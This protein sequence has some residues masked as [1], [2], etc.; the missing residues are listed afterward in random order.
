MNN[1]QGISDLKGFLDEKVEQYNQPQFIETD[2]IQIPKQ[3]SKKEDVEIAGFLSATIAWGNRVA[4]IKNALRLM[5]M[6]DNQP[7]EFVKDA[8]A[9]ELK[10]LSSF[11]HRTFNGEDCLYFILSLRNIYKK[12]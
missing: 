3:F 11:V 2:P 5:S 12:S 7:F 1:Y 4:I 8:S 6:L 9:K 10:T